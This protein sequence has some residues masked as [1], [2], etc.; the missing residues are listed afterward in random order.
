MGRNVLFDWQGIQD[1]ALVTASVQLSGVSRALALAALSVMADQWRWTTDNWDETDAAV[2]LALEEVMRNMMLGSVIWVVGGV[3][4]GTLLCDGS[5]YARADFPNLYDILP[6]VYI[7]DADNFRT[8]NLADRFVRGLSGSSSIGDT[9]GAATHTLT[10][11]E[12]P[13][14]SHTYV[15]PTINIDVEAPGVP[16]PVAA[17]IGLPTQTGNAGGGQAHNNL[18]PYE[19]LRPCLIA[20]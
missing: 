20:R 4:D 17:G 14:H 1:A 9:G 5:T 7:V 8:P 12:M 3:P 11:S 13:V 19:V 6:A 2:S 18:P 15:P 16:D 10:E